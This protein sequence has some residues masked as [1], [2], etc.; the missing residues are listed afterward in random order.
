M[1]NDRYVRKIKKIMSFKE[2]D[3]EILMYVDFYILLFLYIVSRFYISLQI[4]SS[5]V[6]VQVTSQ[7]YFSKSKAFLRLDEVMERECYIIAQLHVMY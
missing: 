6:D 7:K 5:A 2:N 1:Q 3:Y 4:M